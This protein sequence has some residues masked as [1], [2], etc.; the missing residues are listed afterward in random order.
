MTITRKLKKKADGLKEE[1]PSKATPRYEAENEKS[2]P[3][4]DKKESLTA[5]KKETD[6]KKQ[7]KEGV[8]G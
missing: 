4:T 2:L 7:E 8:L 6:I 1:A 3:I 5:D